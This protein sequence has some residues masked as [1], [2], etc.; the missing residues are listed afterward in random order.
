MSFNPTHD[1]LVICGLEDKDWSVTKAVEMTCKKSV[2]GIHQMVGSTLLKKKKV[3]GKVLQYKYQVFPLNEEP[4]YEDIRRQHTVKEHGIWNRALDIP[5]GFKGK[6]FEK[7]DDV[8]LSNNNER[9]EK[10]KLATKSL[11]PSLKKIIKKQ[12]YYDLPAKVMKFRD[13]VDS[14][15]TGIT[16]V[17]QETIYN[18]EQASLCGYDE[19]CKKILQF[20]ADN[21]FRCLKENDVPKEASV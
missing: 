12:D 16:L 4:W 7:Y 15:I 2:E 18:F 19:I 20:W 3:P 21:F 9:K 1:K 10:R 17:Q 13:I 6:S 8:I 11:L 5:E 14:H